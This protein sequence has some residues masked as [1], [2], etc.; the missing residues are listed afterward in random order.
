MP[1]DASWGTGCTEVCWG[2]LPHGLGGSAWAEGFGA[3]QS[4]VDVLIFWGFWTRSRGEYQLVL[5][6]QGTPQS[7]GGVNTLKDLHLPD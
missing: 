6:R 4:Q 5:G 3:L 7:W 1:E 2:C